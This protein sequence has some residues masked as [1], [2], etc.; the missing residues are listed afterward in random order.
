MTSCVEPSAEDGIEAS[1]ASTK[2]AASAYAYRSRAPKVRNNE[3]DLKLLP[4]A[5]STTE[6]RPL[7]VHFAFSLVD[8]NARVPIGALTVAELRDLLL[9]RG[10]VSNADHVKMFEECDGRQQTLHD[11]DLIT[12]DRI[13]IRQENLGLE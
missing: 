5:S 8:F 6:T 7:T 13:V 2:F 10:L 12:A 4:L 3:A 9:N 1:V 11:D